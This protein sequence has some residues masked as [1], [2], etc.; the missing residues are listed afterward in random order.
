VG[1]SGPPVG[2]SGLSGASAGGKYGPGRQRAAN[3]F[4]DS[5]FWERQEY[6][7]D[8]NTDTMPGFNDQATPEKNT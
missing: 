6:S 3:I 1:Q 5:L 4:A 8:P 2:T 7:F